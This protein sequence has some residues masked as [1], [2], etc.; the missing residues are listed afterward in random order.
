M[1]PVSPTSLHQRTVTVPSQGD[2]RRPG[3]R[4]N[5]STYTPGGC[6]WLG[7]NPPHLLHPS[8]ILH[9]AVPPSAPA[10]R[11]CSA[12]LPPTAGCFPSPYSSFA[13][14]HARSDPQA[15][16]EAMLFLFSLPA[17]AGEGVSARR[18]LS[19]CAKGIVRLPGHEPSLVWIPPGSGHLKGSQGRKGPSGSHRWP[20]V[21]EW[22][23]DLSSPP[24]DPKGNTPAPCMLCA[25]CC[26][27]V[28][29][30]PGC[31]RLG[32]PHPPARGDLPAAPDHPLP[33]S[34]P[35][36]A[37]GEAPPGDPHPAPN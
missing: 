5:P 10:K 13:P 11:W 26:F 12:S 32:P 28:Q 6:C 3:T 22:E 18:W 23:Q 19:Q 17:L 29:P 14:R 36:G 25:T 37:T 7:S 16:A 15:P 27:P 20:A 1:A 35:W 2:P 34:R 9:L 24:L 8:A 4:P 33:L 21:S 30:L 31:G